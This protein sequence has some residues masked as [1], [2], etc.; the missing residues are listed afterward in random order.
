MADERTPEQI[1]ADNNLVDAI[2]QAAKAYGHL[3][4]DGW[5][6]GDFA[7]CVEYQGYAEHLGGR[8]RYGILL[9]GDSTPT[10]RV[11]GLLEQTRLDL[12]RRDENE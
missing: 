8:C 9:P 10:H 12:I 3:D 7:V 2:V 11:L 4:E 5:T 6:P 1:A